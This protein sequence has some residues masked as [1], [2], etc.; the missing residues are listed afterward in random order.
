MEYWTRNKSIPKFRLDAICS[1]RIIPSDEA[2][3]V[4]KV[5]SCGRSEA[6][7]RH[8]RTALEKIV[9]ATIQILP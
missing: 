9:L 3:D 4:E 1:F 8:L 6:I 7:D 5:V 2:P